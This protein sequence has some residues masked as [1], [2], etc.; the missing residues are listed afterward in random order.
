MK[1]IIAAIVIIFHTSYVAADEC[2]FDQE[3]QPRIINAIAKMYPGGVIDYENR[4]V[5]WSDP[6]DGI[7]IFVYGGCQHLGSEVSLESTRTNARTQ[8]QVFTLARKLSQRF[9]NNGVVPASR[10]ATEALQK[11]L[12]QHEYTVIQVEGMTVYSIQENVYS[13]LVIEHEYK[14]GIDRVS[15][16]W[17]GNF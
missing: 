6:V 4:Q 13:Q 14:N 7:T 17:V 5:S 15:I 8:E 11:A 3:D 1:L 10:I 9:W 12:N 2:V 16:S